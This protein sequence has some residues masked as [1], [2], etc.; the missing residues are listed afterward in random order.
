[1]LDDAPRLE[2]KA[3]GATVTQILLCSKR[4]GVKDLGAFNMMVDAAGRVLQVD[5]NAASPAQLAAYNAKG[6]QTSHKLD[7]RVWARAVAYTRAHPA[8]VAAFVRALVAT[9]PLRDGVVCPLFDMADALERGDVDGFL[10]H[11]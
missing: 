1:V 6:L 11:W 9:V 4:M 5:L 7:G 2:R 8:A 3:F 10:A